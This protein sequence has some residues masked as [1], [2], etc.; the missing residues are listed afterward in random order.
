[1]SAT[2]FT[3][4]EFGIT[5]ISDGAAWDLQTGEIVRLNSR[6]VWKLSPSVGL[7][8]MGVTVSTTDQ[9]VRS[10]AGL[11]AEQ[12]IH[13]V[14]R[15]L[16]A[17]LTK[18]DLQV[19]DDNNPFNIFTF[20]YEGGRLNYWRLFYHKDRFTPVFKGCLKPGQNGA[21]VV[22]GNSPPWGAL[23][24]K[25]WKMYNPGSDSEVE[26]IQAIEKTTYQAFTEMVAICKA[27]GKNVGGE[28]F[29]ETIR[30]NNYGKT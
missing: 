15:T 5:L 22:D 11:S 10:L 14:A 23:T 21:L 20:G 8:W 2:A 16:K 6:K 19:L 27:E 18:E 1:M 29:M 12:A 3:V 28:I 4:T 25:Y 17:G 24:R 7:V 9:I 30:P 13:Q 26:L